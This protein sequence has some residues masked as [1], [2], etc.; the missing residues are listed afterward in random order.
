MLM[1]NGG[2]RATS[3]NARV[4]TS[5]RFAAHAIRAFQA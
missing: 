3:T 4:A 1:A 2:L 5:R